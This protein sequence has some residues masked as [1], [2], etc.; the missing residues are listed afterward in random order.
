VVVLVL[1]FGG[2][3]SLIG[4]DGLFLL[5][6]DRGSE[7]VDEKY[8]SAVIVDPLDK[9]PHGFYNKYGFIV[10]S[11]SGKMLIPTDTVISLFTCY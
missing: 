8:S 1:D 6:C 3:V 10:L 5:V 4:D 9:E 7:P 11:G 2:S